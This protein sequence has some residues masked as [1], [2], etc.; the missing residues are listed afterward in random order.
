MAA[1]HFFGAQSPA[2]RARATSHTCAKTT[3]APA[4]VDCPH[5]LPRISDGAL[6][7]RPRSSRGAPLQQSNHRDALT[8]RLNNGDE[9]DNDLLSTDLVAKRREAILD[10]EAGRRADALVERLHHLADRANGYQAALRDERSRAQGYRT[11]PFGGSERSVPV[12]NSRTN[13][14]VVYPAQITVACSLW[15]KGAR[16]RQPPWHR[17]AEDR[18]TSP[19]GA[20]KPWDQ[21]LTRR[22]R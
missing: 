6:R 15:L 4:R 1:S 9:D 7:R 20:G 11:Y 17:R 16:R 21:L 13:V 14:S 8:A 18:V 10:H 5:A 12:E 3:A 2:I 22:K 19:A